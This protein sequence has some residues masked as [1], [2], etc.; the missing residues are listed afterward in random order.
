MKTENNK[1]HTDFCYC[2]FTMKLQHKTPPTEIPQFAEKEL[3]AGKPISAQSLKG[4]YTMIDFWGT[5]CAPC[6]DA[7]PH[8]SLSI[9]N[10]V[11]TCKS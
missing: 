7:L 5:W 1:P 3:I 2:L 9:R 10:M 11:T 4:K 6:I 8:W